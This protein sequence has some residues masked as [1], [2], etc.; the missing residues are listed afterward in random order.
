MNYKIEQSIVDNKKNNGRY[1]DTIEEIKENFNN[2]IK[3][4][5]DELKANISEK[6]KMLN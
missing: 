4:I 1:M 5:N 2:Q 3:S 6:M